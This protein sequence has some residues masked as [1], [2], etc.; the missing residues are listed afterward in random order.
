VFKDLPREFQVMESHCGQIEWPPPGW[1][2][3]AAA[4]QGTRTGTQ[5]LR[6]SD[7]YIYAAQFHLE[8]AGT[9]EVSKR[10]MK[11][12]LELSKV[13]GGYNPTGKAASLAR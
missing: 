4:G 9:P 5:C 10:I 8:M 13:W 12:F 11:N 3:I 2:L 6:M 1:K 7:R